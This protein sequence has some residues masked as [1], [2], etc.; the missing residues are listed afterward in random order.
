MTIQ[1][2]PLL[3]IYYYDKTNLTNNS[4]K[5]KHIM[6]IGANSTSRIMNETE[7]A[8]IR[9]VVTTPQINNNL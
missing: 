3:N 9:L 1:D 5:W 7:G 8:I 2:V 4:E 6:K